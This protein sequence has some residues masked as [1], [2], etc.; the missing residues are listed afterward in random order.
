M[1]IN[2]KNSTALVAAVSMALPPMAFAQEMAEQCEPQEIAVTADM[3]SDLNIDLG[4]EASVALE[5]ETP[6]EGMTMV[7]R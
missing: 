6:G 3:A 4:E 1:R 7:A 5:T 2:F